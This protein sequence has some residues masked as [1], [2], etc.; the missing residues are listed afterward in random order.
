MEPKQGSGMGWASKGPTLAAGVLASL[1][2]ARAAAVDFTYSGY[3]REHLSFNLQDAPDLDAVGGS[4]LFAPALPGNGGGT[5]SSLDGQGK[6]S[7]ARATL[8]LESELDFGLFKLSGVG[9]LVREHHTNYER[10]LQNAAKQS[11]L[12]LTD[13]GFL[14]ADPSTLALGPALGPVAVNGAPF[15]FGGKAFFEDYDSEELREMYVTFDVTKRLHFKLGKQQVV[16]GETDFFRAMD[17][18]HGYDMRWRSFLETENEELRKPLI[19]ANVEMAV[20]ELNGRLQLVFRPGWDAG[21]DI[22]NRLP[23]EGQRWASQPLRG[24]NLTN[25]IAPYNYHHDDGDENDANYGF[26][27]SGDWKQIGYSLAYYRGQSN[28]PLGSFNPAIGVSPK[29][30]FG[31]A[32]GQSAGTPAEI[33]FPMV[34]TFGATLNA[35]SEALDSVFRGELAYIPNQ[36]YNTGTNTFLDVGAFAVGC[37]DKTPSSAFCPV[38]R[39]D[40]NNPASAYDPQAAV[41]PGAPALLTLYLPGAGPVVEKQTIKVM[42]GIDKDLSL[43]RWLNTQRPSIWSMQLFD[44]WILNYDG[45]DDIV[46][47]L[48]YGA[49]KRKHTTYLTNAL[50]LN[51]NYDRINPSLAVGFDLG[52]FDGFLIPAVDL[53]FGDHW[54]IRFEA[55]IFLPRH[56]KK[57]N[58]G[59]YTDH[60]TRLLGTMANHDQFVARITYQF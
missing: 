33:I 2:A 34:E 29:G 46:D 59:S 50:F 1:L 32:F 22:G 18:I 35:Y 44:T 9:R 36:P 60:N 45:D 10:D 5:L 17:I 38:L 43:M 24:L 42:F 14:L 8:K 16:W 30:T 51:Y 47:L 13:H 20:P 6:L 49:K 40:P 58:V 12:R 57:D 41:Q 11:P 7:M 19:M 15:G 31:G 37:S 21:D 4:G 52:N 23:F 53:V 39:N 28:D 27:W 3:L 48:S 55:D 54:R 26:R 25:T 56:T